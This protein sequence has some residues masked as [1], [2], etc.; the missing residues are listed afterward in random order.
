MEY[1][2]EEVGEAAL[3][4]LTQLHGLLDSEGIVPL[5][6]AIAV[7]ERTPPNTANG[8]L[9]PMAMKLAAFL[10]AMEQNRAALRE[11]Q[12]G[13][14]TAHTEPD[15][16]RPKGANGRKRKPNGEDSGGS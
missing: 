6:L 14:S 4:L 10:R 7:Y 3:M 8:A 9:Y 12:G 11:A 16:G 13:P 2:A 15:Q 5:P 1:D